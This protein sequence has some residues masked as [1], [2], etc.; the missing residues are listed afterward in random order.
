MLTI[1]ELQNHEEVANA[2]AAFRHELL[3]SAVEDDLGPE[4]EQYHLLMLS[5]LEQAQRYAVLTG[6][7]QD[8][9]TRRSGGAR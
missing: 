3:C 6:F 1:A 7:R 2:I 8:S 9:F 5:A 4:A